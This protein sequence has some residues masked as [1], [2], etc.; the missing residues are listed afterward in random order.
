MYFTN[1]EYANGLWVVTGGSTEHNG[2]FWSTN[3]KAWTQGTIQSNTKLYDVKYANNIWVATSWSKGIFYS[4]DGKTWTQ[5]SGAPTTEVWFGDITYANGTFVTGCR[6][7]RDNPS[8]GTWWSDDGINWTECTG[9]GT[10]YYTGD[11]YYARGIWLSHKSSSG[12]IISTDGKSWQTT[13]ITAGYAEGFCYANGLFVCLVRDTSSTYYRIY[14]A[15]DPYNWYKTNLV[16]TSE[17]SDKF[18]NLLYAKNK[19]LLGGDVLRYSDYSVLVENGFF[20]D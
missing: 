9:I 15:T 6:S 5:A 14:V 18:T 7:F 17:E 1:I 10:T 16:E 19:W 2:A 12:I 13:N 3:G 4:T 11:I 8:K 20:T